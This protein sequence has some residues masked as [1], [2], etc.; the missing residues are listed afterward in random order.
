MTDD[1]DTDN[2]EGAQ[3]GQPRDGQPPDGQPRGGQP[4]G[5]QPQGGQPQGGQPQGGQ[6]TQGGQ[7]QGG[8][9]QHSGQPQG[10]P[11][12]GGQQGR[13]Q[14]AGGQ[15]QGGHG[16]S[17]GGI[18]IEDPFED[19]RSPSEILQGEYVKKHIKY[20]I[21]IFLAIG[22]GFSLSFILLELLAPSGSSA[23]GSGG[24]ALVG[25]IFA[26]ILTPLLGGILGIF[27][28]L[29]MNDTR[30]SAV[31]T[32]GAGSFSGYIVFLFL[33]LFMSAIVSDSGGGIGDAFVA[34]IGWGIGVAVA[35][36]ATAGVTR[37]VLESS[38]DHSDATQ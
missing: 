13:G 14:P 3:G 7:P 35:G 31:L 33:L 16:Q 22:I 9:P 10:Q 37:V 21:G 29:E 18:Q 28:G 25:L 38:L 20:C 12:Q 36:A 6:P 30:K 24:L 15:P 8:Q 26:L 11:T 2:D 34:L 17:G 4:Q 32:A 27:I 5:G 1:S 23:V 19:P